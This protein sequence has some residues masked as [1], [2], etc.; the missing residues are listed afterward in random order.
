M[1]ILR[2]IEV[3]LQ[4][5][6]RKLEAKIG[7]IIDEIKRSLYEKYTDK[8]L[9]KVDQYRSLLFE[10]YDY[11]HKLQ[12]YTSTTK[13]NPSDKEEYEKQKK[14][15]KERPALLL[16]LRSSTLGQKY[17]DDI[18]TNIL[19]FSKMGQSI[20]WYLYSKYMLENLN[21][22]EIV[23]LMIDICIITKQQEITKYAEK[24]FGTMKIEG[25]PKP[26][27]VFSKAMDIINSI[28]RKY[29]TIQQ[30]IG[31]WYRRT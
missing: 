16:K 19:G 3:L 28:E 4:E 20:R 24:T 14:Y 26:V 27:P 22:Q 29:N 2:C 17:G 18:E 6:N 13:Y 23:D 8:M 10:L 30:L 5:Y 21:D 1:K 9:N 31:Y 7:E 15:N 25:Y 11:F 12:K